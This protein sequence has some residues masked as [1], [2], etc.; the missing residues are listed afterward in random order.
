[1]KIKLKLFVFII[2]TITIGLTSCSSII[3]GIYG[4]KKI[5]TVDKYSIHKYAQKFNIPIADC[6]EL[7]SS[8]SSF[9]SSLDTTRYKDQIKNH[10]QPLQV[11]YYNKMGQLQ[12]FHINCYAS[13]FPNLQW[14][15]NAQFNNFPP[16]LQ[17]PLDDILPLDTHLKYIINDST[18]NDLKTDSLDFLVM[19]YW[20]KFMGRQSKRLIQFVQ[21][22][23]KTAV[24]KKVKII[25]INNDNLFARH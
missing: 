13:G 15:L 20:N 10:F 22:N 5:K 23:K 7:D 11:L 3:S 16:K 6:Y 17:A 25:Y 19:V 24:N 2:I 9:L 18:K 4:I 8:Y 12:S 14:S 1:M 21:E